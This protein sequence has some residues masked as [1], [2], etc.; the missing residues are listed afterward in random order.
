MRK[1]ILKP[2][3][4]T[5]ALLL[6]SNMAFSQMKFSDYPAKL[7]KGK[8]KPVKLTKDTRSFRTRFKNMQYASINFAGRYVLNYVGCGTTCS[9][10]M[11]YDTRSG[12][13][14]F[15]P[16]GSLSACYLQDDVKDTEIYFK[17]QSRLLIMAGVFN[18]E[19]SCQT[20][21]YLMKNGKLKLIKT[22]K[23]H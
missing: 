15:L 10:G 2:T 22:T 5:T 14:S 7:Y 11:L 1:S 4:I 13:T 8:Y 6:A 20:R 9:F 16:S 21:Y 3:L 23:F 17:K 19:S 12:K 18:E